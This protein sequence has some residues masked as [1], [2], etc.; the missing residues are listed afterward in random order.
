MPPGKTDFAG[1]AVQGI[2]ADFKEQVRH[3]AAN[4]ERHQNGKGA[5]SAQQTGHMTGEMLFKIF[6]AHGK[7]SLSVINII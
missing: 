3:A 2:G 1:L 5:A 7:A 6:D 4:N